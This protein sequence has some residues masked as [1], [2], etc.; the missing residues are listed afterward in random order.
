MTSQ[1]IRERA[2]EIAGS[3]GRSHPNDLDR[4]RAREGLTGFTSESE[5]LPTREEPGRDWQMP[6]V[7]TG[8]KAPTVRPEDDENIPEKLIQE[9]IEEADHDQRVSSERNREK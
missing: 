4:T 8:E 2:R 5:K 6:L 3:D 9:G 1:M 7:S